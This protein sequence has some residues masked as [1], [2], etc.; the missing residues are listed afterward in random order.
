MISLHSFEKHL[1]YPIFIELSFCS[2]IIE[3]LRY[4][5]TLD[6]HCKQILAWSFKVWYDNRKETGLLWGRVFNLICS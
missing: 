4:F 2:E 3:L 1:I 6:P 5:I